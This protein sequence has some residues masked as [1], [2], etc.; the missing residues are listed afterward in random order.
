MGPGRGLAAQVS[1]LPPAERQPLVPHELQGRRQQ[2]DLRG[3]LPLPLQLFHVPDS[4]LLHFCC[5]FDVC[6][7]VF[8]MPTL[9]IALPLGA[10][11]I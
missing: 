1:L 10:R 8:A 4:L 6:N 2:E 5:Y 11:G 3:G 7:I 9:L